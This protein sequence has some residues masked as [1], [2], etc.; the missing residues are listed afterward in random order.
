MTLFRRPLYLLVLTAAACSQLPVSTTASNHLTAGVAAL[1][2]SDNRIPPIVEYTTALMAPTPTSR[3]ETYG[4]VVEN[5][6]AR[7]LLFALARDGRVNVD[8]HAGIEGTVTLN[9]VE[10]TL[11]QLLT[12]I[13][14]QVDMRWELDGPNIVVMPDSPYLEIYKVDYVNMSRETVGSFHVTTQIASTGSGTADSALAGSNNSLTRIDNKTHN[15]FWETL[16]KNIKEL[17]RE[18]DKILPDGSSETVVETTGQ[19]ETTGTGRAPAPGGKKSATATKTPADIAGSPNPALLEQSASTVVRRS[20]FREAA[21]VI[22]NPEAGVVSVR[23]TSRQHERIQEFL[24]QV[25][26]AARRQVL[27]EATIAEVSLSE[28]YQ[29]GIDWSALPIG[30]AGFSLV[31]RA[32]GEIAAPASSLISLAYTNA[33]SRFG[34]IAATVKLL[35]SFGTVKVLSSPKLSVLNNQTAVLKV[36]DN[37]VYFTIKAD[38][39]ANQTTTTTTYTTNLYSVPVGLVINVTPQVSDADSIVLSIRPSI[40]RKYGEVIDPNP[41]LQKLGVKNAIPVIRTREME[42]VIR[43]DSGSIA[44]MGGLMEDSEDNLDHAVPIV[45]RVPIVG[46]LFQDR[47]ESRHKTELVVFLRPVVIKDASIDGDYAEFR[48]SLSARH[49][50]DQ[51]QSSLPESPEKPSA[52]KGSANSPALTDATASARAAN[53]SLPESEQIHITVAPAK[54]PRTLL[55]SHEAFR[56]GDMA[57]AKTGYEAVL[58]GDPRNGHALRALTAI[59]L[60]QGRQIDARSLCNRILETYPA[61]AFAHAWLSDLNG[62]LNPV[63]T[64]SRLRALLTRQPDDAV[65]H[66]ALGNQL[67]TQQRW[68]EARQAYFHAHLG[69]TGNPDYLFNLAVSMEHLRQ[70]GSAV[71]FYQKA[72]AAA[73]ARPGSLDRA[74]ATERL[75]SLALRAAR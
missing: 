52:T 41:D 35:D 19:Q 56:I 50:L 73:E 59:A 51:A 61:D 53:K 70:P 71:E 63:T 36:V 31:Q 40:S 75:G 3:V 9:A 30:R 20:T 44:I 34:N 33:A 68:A 65:L 57:A 25:L 60:R 5:V 32:A 1:S 69:D 8:V 54:V 29:Q 67:A 55:D 14:R 47:D 39:T 24:G 58:L 64:E 38:T 42:S 26:A 62:K 66:F 48:Q 49:M 2:G 7:D 16:E 27:I 74:I 10:Q 37:I 43:V 6:K 18:T 23:A 28:G 46:N 72:L 15:R 11:P 4:V 45:S 17:L 22:V 21:S 12:R 13:A